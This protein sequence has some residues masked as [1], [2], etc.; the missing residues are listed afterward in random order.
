MH[1]IS[2]VEGWVGRNLTFMHAKRSAALLAVVG[3]VLRRGSMTLTQ[4][5]RALPGKSLTKHKIKRV[6]RLL[7]NPHLH[8]EL[9]LIYQRQARTLLSGVPNPVILVDWSNAQPDRSWQ[10]LMA[11]VSSKGR[12]VPLYQEV[13]PLSA[14]NNGKVHRAFLEHLYAMVPPECTPIVVTDAGFR[15]PWFKAVSD[16][17][18]DW[19]GRVRNGIQIRCPGS[20]W[21]T[22]L[23]ELYAKA[24]GRVQALGR[25]LLS[26]HTPY[27]A[28]LYLVHSPKGKTG[29][30]GKTMTSTACRCRDGAHDPWL[31]ATSL[32]GGPE[33]AQRVRKLYAQRMQIEETFRDLKDERW[34]F[35]LGQARC[36]QDKRWAV[37]LLIAS[38][39]YLAVWLVGLTALTHGWARHFQANTDRGRTVLSTLFLGRE[40]LRHP[41]YQLRLQHLL[42]ALEELRRQLNQPLLKD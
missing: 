32:S 7:G 12:A 28:E 25:C 26:R 3:A 35:G 24:T 29:R 39:A 14:Y 13:H 15:G 36:G 18:W 1:S 19:V 16:L 11:A 22:S 34:S 17:G 31:L 8:A 30:K 20:A 6:D 42:Q 38:L 37:L 5:G 40:V 2:M 41:R 21:W 9:D 33:M 4:L 27:A 23:K 10:V